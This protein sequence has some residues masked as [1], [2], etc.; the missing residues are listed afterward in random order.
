MAWRKPEARLRTSY[1][2]IEREMATR[3]WAMGEAFS[4]A[5]CAAAPALFYANKVMPFGDTHSNVAAYF[6]RLKARPSFARVLRKPSRISTWFRN[7]EAEMPSSKADII[8]AI[9]A[10]YMSNDRKAGRGFPRRRF[11]LHQ[12]V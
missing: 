9:F 8:R 10:A 6:A 3:T 4:L 1:G 7:E 5:D 11:P 12:P 2:M